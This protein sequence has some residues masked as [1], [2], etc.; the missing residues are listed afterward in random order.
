MLRRSHGKSALH[1]VHSDRN[2]IYVWKFVAWDAELSLNPFIVGV[3]VQPVV[4][5][6]IEHAHVFRDDTQTHKTEYTRPSP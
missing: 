6:T 3:K 4:A 1:F 2:R 5:R